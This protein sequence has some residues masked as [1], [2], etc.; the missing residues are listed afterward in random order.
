MR[1]HERP[2]DVVLEA[3]R[4]ASLGYVVTEAGIWSW[5]AQCPVCRATDGRRTLRISETGPMGSPVT[6]RCSNGCTE[7]EVVDALTRT[8]RRETAA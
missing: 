6:L 5:R 4:R 1:P 7:H 3:L 2:A 8:V